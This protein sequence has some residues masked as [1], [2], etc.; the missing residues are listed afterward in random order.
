MRDDLDI[1]NANVLNHQKG[2]STHN[3]WHDLTIDR[4]RYFNR[5]SLFRGEANALHQRDGERAGGHNVRDRRAR[6]QACRGRADNGSFGGATFK[7]PKAPN[8]ILMK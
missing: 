5:A 2:S 4:G 7:V 6:D 1:R 8:A 3:W